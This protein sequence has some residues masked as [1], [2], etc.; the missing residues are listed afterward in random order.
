MKE[1]IENLKTDFDDKITLTNS[2]STKV[3]ERINKLE[4]LTNKISAISRELDGINDEQA[5]VNTKLNE[6]FELL[7]KKAFGLDVLDEVEFGESIIEEENTKVGGGMRRKPTL[8][9]NLAKSKS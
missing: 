4:M 5:G 8:K 1:L 6:I 9:G 7:N 2:N 3:L